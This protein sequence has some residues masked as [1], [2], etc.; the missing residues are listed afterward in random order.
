M[1]VESEL[2]VVV[3]GRDQLSPT[4][5]QLESRVIRWVGAISASMA[6]LKIGTAPVVAS[7]QFEREMANVTKTTGFAKSEIAQ[8]S[9]EILKMSTRIDV[10]AMDLAKIAAAAGQQGLGRFGVEGV[11]AFTDSVSRM[12]SVLDVTA[13]DAGANIG[14]IVNIFKIPLKGIE[15]AISTFN[16]VSNNSTAT[17]EELLDVVK[18]IGDAAGALNLQQSVALAAT[19]MDFG[20]SPEVA[21]TAFSKMFSSLREKATAFSTLLKTDTQSWIDLVEKDGLAAFQRV[22]AAFR[23]LKP[24]DQQRAITKL[25]GGG[26]IGALVNKLVQDTQ[27]TVLT[28]NFEQAMEGSLGTSAIK[29]QETVLNTVVA[30][31]T[32][33]YN[34]LRKVGI[35][36][37]EQAMGPLAQYAAQ[38]NTAL[39]S[40]G[41]KSFLTL[42]AR[43]VL[44]MVDGLAQGVKFVADL[45]VNWEN[46]IKVAKVFLQL[47]LAQ[48]IGGALVR[49]VGS[50]SDSVKYVVSG[51]EAATK[52]SQT[53]T[54]AQATA[55]A[56]QVASDAAANGSIASRV[57]GYT[58]LQRKIMAYVAAKKAEAAA[59][60]DVARVA[61]EAAAARK[62]ATV[63]GGRETIANSQTTSAAS[64][65]QTQRAVLAAAEAAAAAEQNVINS[66]Q[67]AKQEAALQKTNARRLAIE[68]D[69]QAK[70]KVIRDTGT[71]VGLTALQREREQLLAI[72]EASYQR[73]LRGINAYYS[74]RAAEAAAGGAALVNA[75]RAAYMRVIGDFDGAVAKQASRATQAAAA[76]AGAV[77]A[78]ATLAATTARLTAMQRASQIAGAAMISFGTV[79]RTVASVVAT[80]GRLIASGFF[81]VTIIYSIADSFGLLDGLGAKFQKFTDYLG[82]TSEASRRAKVETEKQ[83]KALQDEA[84][85]LDDLIA[86][87]D[88]FVNA[89]TGRVDRKEIGRL[90]QIAS[91]T[92]DESTRQQALA[93]LDEFARALEAKRNQLI[94]NISK[95]NTELAQAEQQKLA[96]YQK[97]LTGLLKTDGMTIPRLDPMQFGPDTIDN[98]ERIG[99][100]RKMMAESEKAL[101]SLKQNT[102]EGQVT[103]DGLG[104]S[105]GEV[106]EAFAG[107]FT[108]ETLEYAQQNVVAFADLQTQAKEAEERYKSLKQE[109]RG[110]SEAVGAEADNARVAFENLSRQV[111]ESRAKLTEFAAEQTRIPGLPDNVKASWETLLIL[112]RSAPGVART[113]IA[114]A[115]AAPTAALT[116]ANA[117]P[118]IKSPTTG[119]DTFNPKPDKAAENRARRE[120][121]ARLELERT[122]IQQEA[123]LQEEASR[124]LLENDTRM[125]DRGLKSVK[126]YYAERNRVRLQAN[127]NDI[128]DKQAELKAVDAEIAAAKEQAEKLKFE[129]TATRLRG[130]IAVLQAQRA[131]IAAQ[132]QEDQRKAAETFADRMRSEI[133]KLGAQGIIPTSNVDA[134]SGNLSELE[135]QYRIFIAQLRAEGQGAIADSLLQGLRGDA[136]RATLAP[137][138]EDMQRMQESVS[139]YQSA[140]NQAVTDGR[141]TAE[142]ATVAYNRGIQSQIAAMEALLEQQ[143]EMMR[144]N[145]EQAGT[146]PYEQLRLD[147]E[148]TR[149]SL[150]TLRSE[151][152]RVA[153]DFNQSVQGSLASF[154][155]NLEPTFA[156]V[157][158]GF[159]NMLLNIAQ[160]MQQRV[161]EA[162]AGA[163]MQG[164]GSTG[165]GGIGGVL[166]EL[167][168]GP[169]S[170]AGKMV[171][172]G[173]TPATPMFVTD[174]TSGATE[175]LDTLLDASPLEEVDL[176]P[177][178]KIQGFIS[179]WM[180]GMGSTFSD[181]LGGLGGLFD[182][183]GDSLGSLFSGLFS[184]M[185]GGGGGGFFSS[186]LGLFGAAHRGGVAGSPTMFRKVNPEVFANAMRYHIGGTAG[187]APGLRA[188]EVPT[189]LERG[190]TIRTQQQEAAVQNALAAGQSGANNGDINVYVVSPDAVPTSVSGQDIVVS[191]SDNISKRGTIYQLIKSIPR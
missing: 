162:I 133:N 95:V 102:A 114:A 135:A 54:K 32:A 97:E 48:Y 66:A 160:G 94:G 78:D 3:K 118:N 127:Q 84:K 169:Q 99:E 76:G 30:Q 131:S 37:T 178:G 82:L 125:F 149:Q 74:K 164:L 170:M 19:A 129:A 147:I 179:E 35:E 171:E 45:N 86:K 72:E 81:W 126:D 47:K 24:E 13:E 40:D 55:T 145:A 68:E 177:D 163:V 113:A 42:V 165:A 71:R 21:G 167:V 111:A 96:D 92:E 6:A 98:S 159:L 166:Q 130:D 124:Q 148:R 150:V 85:A 17:G 188:N 184:G 187:K 91:T 172:R 93:Q 182:G 64:L 138:Q 12:S 146:R 120:A 9:G 36:A 5:A 77:A 38:L 10:S 80:A 90:V 134:F 43:S 29:E 189:I 88:E 61:A 67:A 8:L 73:S 41:L 121:R 173:A 20:V 22:L 190:E 100:L 65:A 105:I 106:S 143:K 69:F 175:T 14:K 152:N 112:L 122:R 70:R 27:N 168:L 28:R 25:F 33:A 49:S 107:M 31:A 16:Q 18:R 52:A 110:G 183:F 44:D 157:K 115:T 144:L 161:G 83:T 1:A 142:Q 116:G 89:S 34:S 63:A 119:N 75:E 139:L 103:L 185:G 46:F 140:L 57:F 153:I 58:E 186:I 109:A 108:P 137:L 156:S 15:T 141:V 136:L 50:F 101:A 123:R 51:T 4:L 23:D 56:A 53:L 155:G 158:E 132:E 181:L 7:A 79:M 62:A 117:N 191:V 180:D 176:L 128:D 87:Y 60:A 151:Q 39:Q 59:E 26:R 154:L 11:V 174:V 2:D 104:K